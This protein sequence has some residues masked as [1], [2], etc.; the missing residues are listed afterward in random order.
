MRWHGLGEVCLEVE[1]CPCD[2]PGAP[3]ASAMK[4]AKC[5][6]RTGSR[7]RARSDGLLAGYAQCDLDSVGRRA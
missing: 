1:A 5:V 4:R 2:I 7:A 3:R 6:S